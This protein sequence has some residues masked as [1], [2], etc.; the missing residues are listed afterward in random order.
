MVLGSLGFLFF[1]VWPEF[2]D[3]LS[4]E[5]G[6]G[7]ESIFKTLLRSGVTCLAPAPANVIA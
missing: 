3:L 6:L 4:S 5:A 2:H 7:W 1:L